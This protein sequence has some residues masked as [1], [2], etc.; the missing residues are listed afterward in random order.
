MTDDNPDN[1]HL[2]VDEE[3]RYIDNMHLL[4]E[5]E[6][7]DIDKMVENY[8]SSIEE[9]SNNTLSADPIVCLVE[10]LS[11]R[12]IG[13]I[14]RPRTPALSLDDDDD[15]VPTMSEIM[16]GCRQT[17]KIMFVMLHLK[18]QNPIDEVIKKYDI[19]FNNERRNIIN[20]IVNPGT[21][22]TILT[23]VIND[24]G[25][26]LHE[27]VYSSLSNPGA[28]KH[29]LFIVQVLR[30]IKKDLYGNPMLIGGEVVYTEVHTF[31]VIKLIDNRYRVLSSWYSGGD[32]TPIISTDLNYDELIDLLKPENLNGSAKKLW[33]DGNKF[34][35]IA[36]DAPNLETIF[37][38]EAAIV[39]G[40]DVATEYHFLGKRKRREE[41]SGGKSKKWAKKPK[42]GK[43][44]QKRAK[45]SKRSK[46][47]KRGKKSQ[48]KAKYYK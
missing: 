5:K 40:A 35:D 26:G 29:R 10:V 2:L 14:L 9:C 39:Y 38:S 27:G 37:I 33:G 7:S 15:Y 34:D 6:R 43:K 1:T 3:R 22:S 21:T 41:V 36:G 44:S 46:K 47:V 30:L 20:T 31:I 16:C 4:A 48:K 12:R 8:N 19:F 11:N 23:R 24:V 28:R 17:A 13:T 42:M 32:A 45:K 18:L 25:S